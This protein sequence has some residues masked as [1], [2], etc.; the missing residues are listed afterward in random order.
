[1]LSTDFLRL[2]LLAN[3]L[4]WPLAYAIA[5]GWLESF[6]FRIDLPVGA[7]VMA[8]AMAVSVAFLSVS[9]HAVRVALANPVESL[10][11]E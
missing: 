9:Y 1:M 6:A 8:G 2:L 3:V 7:F 4:A 11:Y 5:D 10:R